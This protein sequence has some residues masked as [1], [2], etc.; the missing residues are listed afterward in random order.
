MKYIDAVWQMLCRRLRR[1]KCVEF[2]YIQLNDMIEVKTD[3]RGH[4]YP[5][6]LTRLLRLSWG[7]TDFQL[8]A[9][10]TRFSNPLKSL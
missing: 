10:D 9:M 7:S 8:T 3:L 1:S 5:I 4:N 2:L 6:E